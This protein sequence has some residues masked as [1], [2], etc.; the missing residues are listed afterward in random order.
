MSKLR[1]SPTTT[2]EVINQDNGNLSAGTGAGGPGASHRRRYR[3]RSRGSV[4]SAARTRGT[5]GWRTGLRSPGRREPRSRNH[6]P[7]AAGS[8][9]HLDHIACRDHLR[10]YTEDAAADTTPGRHLPISPGATARL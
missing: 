10:A 2:H 9:P 8:E 5:L 6:Y 4:G 3:R 1:P 7:I